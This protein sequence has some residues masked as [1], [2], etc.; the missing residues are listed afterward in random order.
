MI[1][2]GEFLRR[3]ASLMNRFEELVG[4]LLEE[5]QLLWHLGCLGLLLVRI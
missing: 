1:R 2:Q 3:H 5:V 4:D